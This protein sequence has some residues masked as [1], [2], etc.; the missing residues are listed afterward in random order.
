MS[1]TVLTGDRRLRAPDA[2]G[3]FSVHLLEED[4]AA[5]AVAGVLLEVLAGLGF[6]DADAEVTDG[7]AALSVGRDVVVAD[8]EDK[9]F[10]PGS[11]THFVIGS[12][13]PAQ[14]EKEICL[15]FS[16]S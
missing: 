12:P 11:Q 3:A 14:A 16:I 1:G 10:F 8:A 6:L 7:L 2:Y 4:V 15:I 5:R 9:R 13:R